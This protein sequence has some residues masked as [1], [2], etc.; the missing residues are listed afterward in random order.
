[1]H[2]NWLKFKVSSGTGISSFALDDSLL[3]FSLLAFTR[4]AF[5]FALVT[6]S[7]ILLIASS[8]PAK[9]FS[10][11]IA[12]GSFATDSSLSTETPERFALTKAA[13]AFALVTR[14]SI[15]LIASSSPA[16]AFSTASSINFCFSSLNLFSLSM[17]FPLKSALVISTNP[18][19]ML[20]AWEGNQVHKHLQE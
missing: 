4:A 2:N 10:T 9:A 1:M 15:L 13:F 12:V 3:G 11:A 20:L 19:S 17:A 16:K 7:S 14:S 18:Q 6:R 5:A 8:S